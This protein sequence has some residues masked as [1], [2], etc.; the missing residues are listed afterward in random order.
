MYYCVVVDGP[1][2]QGAVHRQAGD[3]TGPDQTA[4]RAPAG[5]WER[6]PAGRGLIASAARHTS[7]SDSDGVCTAVAWRLAASSET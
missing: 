5:R 4:S 2:P 6:A 1:L 3:V 7:P